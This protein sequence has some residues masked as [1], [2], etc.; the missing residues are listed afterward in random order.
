M[1]Q[2]DFI[3][4]IAVKTGTSI[5]ECGEML[6]DDNSC[7]AVNDKEG[8]F[9]SYVR[10]ET[11]S[12]ALNL[13]IGEYP[14]DL[15]SMP[16][17]ISELEDAKELKK[18]IDSPLNI[19]VL[20]GNDKKEINGLI[21]LKAPLINNKEIYLTREYNKILPDK[22]KKILSL[23]SHMADKLAISVFLV[24]GV[25]RDLI[26]GIKSLDIDITVEANAIEFSR[27]LRKEYPDKVTLKEIH[28]DFKTTK[29]IFNID[30]ENIELDIA[31]TRKEGY[32]YPASLPKLCETGVNIKDDL[33]RR[34]FTINSMALSLNK[35]SFCRLIDPLNGYS[36]IEKKK[37]KII[38]PLSFVE[39]PTRII[40]ALKFSV[41]FDYE[42]DNTTDFLANKC[43]ESGLFDNLGGERLKAAIKQTF[44]LNKKECFKEFI[45]KKLYKMV[46]KEISS[47]E[48]PSSLGSRICDI[49]KKYNRCLSS[50]DYIWL[51][52]FGAM[53][54]NSQNISGISERMLL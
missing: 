45:S 19:A 30:G 9:I 4:V 35:A 7:L 47:P 21:S 25:V 1:E 26:K 6:C 22:I 23:I 36:D 49:T 12:E 51:I 53:L 32:P 40:R 33:S 39:D 14:I 8:N 17:S 46:D 5:Y 44:N 48:N 16:A 11:L 28:D 13:G 3:K 2:Y 42:L 20:I 29:L 15:I 24:G 41:R 34:D 38:H 43:V 10:K 18:Y 37:I 50:Q 54:V 31:S 27:Q 52:Y